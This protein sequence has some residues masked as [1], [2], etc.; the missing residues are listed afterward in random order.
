MNHS[1]LVIQHVDHEGPDLI[2]E[3]A[4]QREMSIQ[5]IRPDLGEQLPD[6]ASTPDTIA[7]VL[8]GPM[9]VNQRNEPQMD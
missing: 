9:G 6:P 4:M 1:L 5:T 8:G 7:V 2:G 3:L